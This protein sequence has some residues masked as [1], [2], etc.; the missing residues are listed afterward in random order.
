MEKYVTRKLDQIIIDPNPEIIYTNRKLY[1]LS[2]NLRKSVGYLSAWTQW[3]LK[4][5]SDGWRSLP[6]FTRAEMDR[7]IGECGKRI[8]AHRPVPTGLRKGENLP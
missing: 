2:T 7:Y 8:S 1:R 3:K 5:P 4:I 6:F